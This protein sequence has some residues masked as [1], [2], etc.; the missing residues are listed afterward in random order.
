M[1]TVTESIVIAR[2][3]QEVWDFLEDVGN[4]PRWN[5]MFVHQ[6]LVDAHELAPGVTIRSTAK[7]VGRTI[8]ADAVMTQVDAPHRST[9]T[10][11]TPFPATGSYVFEEVPGGTLFT[12]HMDAEPGL[13]GVFGILADGIVIAM[14][15]MQLRRSMRRLKRH[16][17][18]AGKPALE[19]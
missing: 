9:L 17:E 18:R 16:L 14:V 11:S 13:G 15:R 12:W 2:P 10:T 6:E 4:T 3:R 5:P 8:H 7:M 1:P 19:V